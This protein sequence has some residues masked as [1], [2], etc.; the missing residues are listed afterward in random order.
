MRDLFKIK[1]N[2]LSVLFSLLSEWGMNYEF[3]FNRYKKI[4][5]GSNRNFNLGLIE[6]YEDGYVF[7]F[8]IKNSSFLYLTYDGF[9]YAWRIFSSEIFVYSD[10]ILKNTFFE[11]KENDALGYFYDLWNYFRC[12]LAYSII[13]DILKNESCFSY[14]NFFYN[15]VGKIDKINLYYE[16]KNLGEQ[17]KF[18]KIKNFDYLYKDLFLNKVKIAI[19]EGYKLNEKPIFVDELIF[20]E[21]TYECNKMIFFNLYNILCNEENVKNNLDTNNFDYALSNI[22]SLTGTITFYYLLENEFDTIYII[23]NMRPSFENNFYNLICT[24]NLN[25]NLKLIKELNE[26]I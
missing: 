8:L 24:R 9:K 2:K 17:A 21:K 16:I 19:N 4:F 15:Y 14:Y 25:S 10:E 7:D 26:N 5:G 1:A 22:K 3:Y 13:K 20:K 23:V 11:D 6:L 12:P 18:K